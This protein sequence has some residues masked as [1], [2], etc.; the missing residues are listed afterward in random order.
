MVLAD[1][2]RLVVDVNGACLRLLGFARA[3]VVNRP[4]YEFVAGDPV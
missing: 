3:D 4:M 2:D 1:D